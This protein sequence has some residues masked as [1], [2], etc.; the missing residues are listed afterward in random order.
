MAQESPKQRID[1]ELI[2]L[3]NELRVALPGVQV[4]FAF[5]LAVPFQQRLG[6]ATTFQ[7]DIYFA[8]LFSALVATA[9][10]VAPA[11]MHRLNFRRHDKRQI[12]AIAS[13]LAIAGLATLGLALVLV[14]LLISDVLFGEP[15]TVVAPIAATLVL[16]LLWAALP[17]RMRA[18]DDEADDTPVGDDRQLER[19]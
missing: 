2:E 16:A 6:R 4:L 14:I 11:D 15:M 7:R 12:V 19:Q 5:L 9:L 18:A 13:R 8:T 10:L 17:L 1:R 3:L